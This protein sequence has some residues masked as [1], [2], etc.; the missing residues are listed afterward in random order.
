MANYIND[1]IATYDLEKHRYL[2]SRHA[3]EEYLGIS[4]SEVLNSEGSINPDTLPEQF[5]NLA[6]LA[7][8]TFIYRY[9]PNHDAMEYYISLPK[10]RDTIIE[11][12]I[13]LIYAYILNNKPLGLFYSEK[14]EELVPEFVKQMLATRG[15]LE[16]AN[17]IL[18][19]NYKELR[20]VD[21]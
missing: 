14:P 21:Y 20:G 12:Q 4:L 18:P 1:D 17:L 3:V 13:Q 5:I 2:V 7:L 16:R 6:S 9:N 10:F 11:A 8:Y 19:H 15:L